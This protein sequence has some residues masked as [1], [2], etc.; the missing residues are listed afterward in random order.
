MNE[1]A[2]TDNDHADYTRQRVGGLCDS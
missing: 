2:P 1:V